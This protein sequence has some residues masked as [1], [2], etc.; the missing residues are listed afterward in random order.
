MPT[1]VCS[2]ARLC[3]HASS[4]HSS[5]CVCICVSLPLDLGCLFLVG[6]NISLLM[7]VQ[8]RVVILEFSQEKMS[9]CPSTPPSWRG[10][11]SHLESN[12]IPA[13]DAQRAQTNLVCNRTQR[14]H[15]D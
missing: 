10:V 11:K 5:L 3:V 7:V 13:R 6:S 14:S 9:T 15:R 4:S 12:P 2:Y 1:C 8:Q